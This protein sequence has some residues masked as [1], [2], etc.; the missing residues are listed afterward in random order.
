[1]EKRS[2]KKNSAEKAAKKKE[3]QCRW[4]NTRGITCTI[5]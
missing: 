3:K 2:A 1:M 5:A 4:H